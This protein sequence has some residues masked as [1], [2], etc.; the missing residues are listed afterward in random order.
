MRLHFIRDATTE[1]LLTAFEWWFWRRVLRI[2]WTAYKTN[3]W[4]WQNI[5]I[6]LPEENGLLEQMENGSWPNMG[7]GRE[8][9]K[10]WLWL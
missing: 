9:V 10:G 3:V 1:K 6:G 4:V 7:T 5:G 8:E 2:S